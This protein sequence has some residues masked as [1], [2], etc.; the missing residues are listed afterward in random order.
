M[1]AAPSICPSTALGWTTKPTSCT[2]TYFS[3]F[4]LPVSAS[5][6]TMAAWV[7]KGW[8]LPRSRSSTWEALESK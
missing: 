4:T 8:E 2:A 5:T 7:Q 1:A 6:S 3:I